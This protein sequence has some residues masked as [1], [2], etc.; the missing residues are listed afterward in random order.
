MTKASKSSGVIKI[1]TG[2]DIAREKK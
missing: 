1:F 2:D